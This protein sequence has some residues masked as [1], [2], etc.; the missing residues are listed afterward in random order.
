MRYQ[1]ALQAKRY[2]GSFTRNRG[3]S[4]AGYTNTMAAGI[5]AG[6]TVWSTRYPASATGLG[7]LKWMHL[8]FICLANFTL[9]VTAGRRLALKRGSGGDASG[10]TALDVMLD[11]S[12]STETLWTGQVATTTGLTVTGV[13]YETAARRRLMLSHTGAANADYDEL[14]T[15]DD[16]LVAQPGQ[17][18][19]IVAPS[20]FDAAGTWQ[21]SVSAGVFE[22]S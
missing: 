14:W 3:Q 13:T 17:S 5:T 8:H 7:F 9:P 20:T 11:Q 19:A 21:L 10:G 1:E 18:F 2:F 15:F 16:P 22:L 6:S 4:L 12:T